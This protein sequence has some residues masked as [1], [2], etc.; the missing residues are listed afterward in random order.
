MAN[1]F[2]LK[3]P[4]VTRIA[5]ISSTE[6]SDMAMPEFKEAEKCNPV[7]SLERQKPEY[8]CKQN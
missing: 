6:T 2:G 1:Y 7:T 3:L 8:I 5:H 4:T